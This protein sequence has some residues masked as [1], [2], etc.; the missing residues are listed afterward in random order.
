MSDGAAAAAG[1]AAGPAAAA[2]GAHAAPI[3]M[4]PLPELFGGNVGDAARELSLCRPAPRRRSARRATRREL[5][6]DDDEEDEDAEGADIPGDFERARSK[7]AEEW[8]ALCGGVEADVCPWCKSTE[9]GASAT[10]RSSSCVPV[11]TR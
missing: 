3:H 10:L 1:D 11:L 7:A 5:N 6:E 4:M 8:A 2:G 9:C